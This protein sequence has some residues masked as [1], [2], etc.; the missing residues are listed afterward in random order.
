MS[1]SLPSQISPAGLNPRNWRF[2]WEAQSHTSTLKLCLFNPLIEPAT[3]F[4]D[5]K[6][7]LVM[8]QFLLLVSFSNGEAQ[9]SLRVPIPRIFIDHESP[10]YFRAYNDHIEVKLVLLLPVDHPLVSEF[11]SVSDDFLP[12][13]TDSDS[14]KRCHQS[15]GKMWLTI[16]L[17]LAVA[18]LEVSARRWSPDM[19][20]CIHVQLVPVF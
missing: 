14:L 2:T 4:S 3:Q 18:H 6:V 19:P 17:G 15:I 8:E 5:L 11:G 9:T 16:G 10:V 12:L 20:S 1:S 13:S 7:T